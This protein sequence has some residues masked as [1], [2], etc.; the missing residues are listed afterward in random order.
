MEMLRQDLASMNEV[1]P[2]KLPPHAYTRIWFWNRA[3][4]QTLL[5]PVHEAQD[6]KNRL[7]AEDAIVWHTEVYGA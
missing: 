2:A 1:K 4:A 6:I 5:C 7:I 3:G